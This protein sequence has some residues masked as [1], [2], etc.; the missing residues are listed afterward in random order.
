MKTKRLTI[1]EVPEVIFSDFSSQHGGKIGQHVDVLLKN[2]FR[3]LVNILWF[4]YQ[5]LDVGTVRFQ[6]VL[7]VF[8]YFF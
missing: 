8:A 6:H 2:D 3:K 5:N 4:L 1:L 7:C